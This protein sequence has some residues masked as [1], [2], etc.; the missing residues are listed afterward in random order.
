MQ[1]MTK[2]YV[3]ETLRNEHL[4]K[5]GDT[6]T[7]QIELSQLWEFTIR[8][9]NEEYFPYIYSL[10]GRKIGTNETWSRRYQD[11]DSAFLHI[12]NNLNENTAIK[13]KYENINQWLLGK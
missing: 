9:E 11:M 5:P 13:N 4:W 1:E 12:V 6:N 10:V 2:Q 3:L 8:K 7:F